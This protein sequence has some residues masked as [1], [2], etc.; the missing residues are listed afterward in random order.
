MKNYNYF[1]VLAGL[2]ILLVSACKTT[3]HTGTGKVE[4]DTPINSER[5]LFW[6]VS[7][8]DLE[9][10]SYIFGTMHL[11]RNEQFH[12][13]ENVTKKL[14]RA[15]QLIMEVDLEKVDVLGLTQAALLSDKMSMKDYLSEEEAGRLQQFFNDSLDINPM[16]F[17][18]AYS[19]MKPF[20]LEQLLVVQYLG[21]N[22]ASYE[23]E[24][25]AMAQDKNIPSV[26]LETFEDQIRFLDNIPLK[27][28]YAQLVES[29]D[30]FTQIRIQFDHMTQ[31]YEAGDLTS[32]AEMIES[33]WD[34]SSLYRK[35]L[36]DKRNQDWI[37]KLFSYFKSGKM[38]V[39]VGA[40]HLGGDNGI[41]A[42][43]RKAGY[44][45]DPVSAD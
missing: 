25:H 42:L 29:V 24:F 40:G 30:S 12:I 17:S 21:E 15:E 10:P 37:P 4:L 8:N 38:F 26:G 45:V 18:T 39:A 3:R 23:T 36:L 11:I 41:I 19:R 20:F 43:L 32:L 31:A 6:Q 27:E 22:A 35:L 9:Q 7:G 2:S 33:E 28:Q 14:L 34:T 5:T 1:K 44:T 16:I 13:G